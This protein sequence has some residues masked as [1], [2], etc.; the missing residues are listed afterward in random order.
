VVAEQLVVVLGPGALMVAA[1]EDLPQDAGDLRPALVRDLARA[2]AAR[3]LAP[4]A[5]TALLARLA[6]FAAV[7]LVGATLLMLSTSSGVFG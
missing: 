1:V 6:R 5:L 7:G 2:G 3:R 4:V